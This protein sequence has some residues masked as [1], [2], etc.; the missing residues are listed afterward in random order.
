MPSLIVVLS[1]SDK[2]AIES[3]TLGLPPS[4]TKARKRLSMYARMFACMYSACA[5]ACITPPTSTTHATLSTWTLK[6]LASLTERL[7]PAGVGTCIG[8][9]QIQVEEEI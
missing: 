7:G 5:F 6:A 8:G 9:T 3:T 2:D 1:V 4:N